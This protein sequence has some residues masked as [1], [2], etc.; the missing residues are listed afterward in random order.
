MSPASPE[1]TRTPGPAVEVRWTEPAPRLRI[2][3][4]RAAG[5]SSTQPPVLMLHGLWHAG[6]AWE[7]WSSTLAAHG[8][9]CYAVDFRGHGASEGDLREARLGHYLEDARRAVADQIGRAHV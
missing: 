8:Y 1:P 5:C 3:V 7:N 2:V 9:D 4:T 6:W